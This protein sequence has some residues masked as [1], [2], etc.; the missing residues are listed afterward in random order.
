MSAIKIL[1]YTEY[2]QIR[3]SPRNCI[4]QSRRFPEVIAEKDTV[5]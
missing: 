4:A 2:I 1:G 3:S 5:E